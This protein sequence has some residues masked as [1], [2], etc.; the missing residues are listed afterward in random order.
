[1]RYLFIILIFFKFTYSSF[2]EID[3][4]T[5]VV[6]PNRTAEDLS[7]IGSSVIIIS[8]EEIENSTYNNTSGILQEFGGF[9]VAQK[10]NRGSDPGYN[11]RGL[12]RKYIRVLVDGI[13]ISDITSVAE[14]PTYLDNINLTNINSIEILNGSQ[15]T[16]YGSNAIAGVISIDSKK[17]DKI[18]LSQ[19]ILLEKGS[20]GSIKNSNT[21][22]WGELLIKL[23]YR[24]NRPT[25]KALRHKAKTFN[26]I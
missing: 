17:A 4:G 13:D 15:G 20:Y 1:M 8:N 6:T 16:L 21:I 25:Y 9:T 24:L 5:I 2:A 14:E 22:K 11:I 3:L 26:V 19:E 18:G 10:G 23:E 7:K 12:Q